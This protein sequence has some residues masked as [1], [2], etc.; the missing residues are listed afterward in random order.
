MS[1]RHL[2]RAIRVEGDFWREIPGVRAI[3]DEILYYLTEPVKT[4][5]NRLTAFPFAI[6]TGKSVYLRGR[7]GKP[8]DSG[9]YRI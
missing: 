4:R 2:V 3:G 5:L 9:V 7:Y 6:F 1:N 8:G